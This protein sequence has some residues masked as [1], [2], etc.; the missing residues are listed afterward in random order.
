MSCED[1]EKIQD[2]AFNKNI[3][4]TTAIVYIR[5]GVANVA[6]VGCRKHCKELINRSKEVV[7]DRKNKNE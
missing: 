4:E 7:N 5:I 1:C 6:I 3:P 2:L